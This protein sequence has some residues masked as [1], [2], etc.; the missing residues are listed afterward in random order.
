MECE[1]QKM[2]QKKFDE[3]TRNFKD[4]KGLY[5]FL[6]NTLSLITYNGF[7]HCFCDQ[8]QKRKLEMK[9]KNPCVKFLLFLVISN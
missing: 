4:R 9:K 6:L 3:L 8:E 1:H 7:C 5:F 2:S